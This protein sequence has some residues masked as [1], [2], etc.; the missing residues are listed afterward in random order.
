MNIQNILVVCVGNICRS[1]MA[2]Y[3]L[4]Q[5]GY[6]EG[7]R[8]ASEGKSKEANELFIKVLS[9]NRSHVYSKSALKILDDAEKGII[10]KETAILISKGEL[11]FINKKYREAVGCFE[12]AL[13]LNADYPEI[14]GEIGRAYLALEQY[15]QAILYMQKAIEIAPRFAQC[16]VGLGAAYEALGEFDNAKKNL[17]RAA[18]LFQKEGDDKMVKSIMVHLEQLPDQLS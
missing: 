4:K 7:V 6:V 12:E 18:A 2:E 14:Y 13:K 3:F 9:E 5:P 8:L 10:K 15:K 1:P 11:N 16:Y 17:L